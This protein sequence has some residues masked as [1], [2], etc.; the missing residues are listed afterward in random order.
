MR[1]EQC[2]NEVEG[3]IIYVLATA[4]P[5]LAPRYDLMFGCCI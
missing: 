2:Q 5:R 3:V 4:I 1:G